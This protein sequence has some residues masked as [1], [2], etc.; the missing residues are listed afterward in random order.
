M[1]KVD[2]QVT[3]SATAYWLA[4]DH[5]RLGSDPSAEVSSGSHALIWWLTGSAGDAIA[6]TASGDAT[7]TV[8][9]SIPEGEI[10]SAG[11]KIFSV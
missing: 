5:Q 11:F 7:F 6:I 2:F 3:S 8:N 1:A 10:H 9:D 4:V